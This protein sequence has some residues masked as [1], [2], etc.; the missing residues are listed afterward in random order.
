MRKLKDYIRE[1]WVRDNHDLRVELKT[2]KAEAIREFAERLKRKSYI[3]IEALDST[4]TSTSDSTKAYGSFYV[5]QSFIDKIIEDARK[6]VNAE[7]VTAVTK[8]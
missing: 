8:Y 3:T 2:A 4:D 6:I 1:A 5:L 7:E